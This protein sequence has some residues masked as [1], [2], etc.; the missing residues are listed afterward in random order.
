MNS[1]E[2]IKDHLK[3]LRQRRAELLSKGRDFQA[4]N[5]QKEIERYEEKLKGVEMKKNPIRKRAKSIG[6]RSQITGKPPSARLKRRRAAV[7]RRHVKGYWPNPLRQLARET[8]EQWFLRMK[9]LGAKKFTAR[10]GDDGQIKEFSAWNNNYTR[11]FGR[12]RRNR[13]KK[14]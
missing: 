5:I 3:W 8:M 12:Y 1:A 13:R 2:S 9:R 14:K 11:E 6:R 10:R 4:K 7:K